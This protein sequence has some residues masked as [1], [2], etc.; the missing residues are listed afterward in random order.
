MPDHEQVCRGSQNLHFAA[1]PHLILELCMEND[2]LVRPGALDIAALA[3]DPRNS[4]PL[5]FF[6]VVF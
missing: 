6:L 1:P 2:A 5:G 3:L 4:L